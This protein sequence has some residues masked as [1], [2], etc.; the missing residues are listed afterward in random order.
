M[1]RPTGELSDAEFLEGLQGYQSVAGTYIR[2]GATI[3]YN[4]LITLNPNG[5]LP[6]NQPFVREIRALIRNVSVTQATNAAGVTNLL[7][8]ERVEWRKSRIGSRNTQ[9]ECPRRFTLFAG[10]FA[11]GADVY[12]IAA[13]TPAPRASTPRRS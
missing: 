12:A 8:Y 10:I 13:H 3:I 5:M 4:R 6:E 1:D 9:Q 7:I 11:P 2:D